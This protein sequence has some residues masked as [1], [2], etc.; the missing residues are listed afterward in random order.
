ST[1]S[2]FGAGDCS[3]I[4]ITRR[5]VTL[6]TRSFAASCFVV[7]PGGRPSS[8]HSSPLAAKLQWV[9]RRKLGVLAG[10]LQQR[11]VEPVVGMRRRLEVCKRNGVHVVR[12]GEA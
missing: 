3:A 11:F 10:R 1:A 4:P 12:C 8:V 2:L 7:S 5:F 9:R 6:L